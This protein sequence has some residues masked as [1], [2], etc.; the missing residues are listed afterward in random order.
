[1][2]LTSSYDV[3]SLIKVT[4]TYVLDRTK[5]AVEIT[6]TADFSAPTD[7]GS[8]FITGSKWKE[9]GPGSFLIYE[10]KAAVQTT[11]TLED[12]SQALVN[13]VEPLK[14]HQAGAGYHPMRLGFNLDKPVLH[15]VMHT[16]IVPVPP[17]TRA[18]LTAASGRG[19]PF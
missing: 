5:P 9:E 15:V 8:A 13:K 6:D 4:R 19:P 12:S 14:M 17:P 1:M 3:P 10:K 2:D 16:V 7:Y 11:V 18:Q